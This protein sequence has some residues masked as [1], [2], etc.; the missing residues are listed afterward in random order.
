MK[1]NILR[2]VSIVFIAIL[3]F[4]FI[5]SEKWFKAGSAP[6]QY[7]MGPDD[8][9]NEVFSIKSISTDLDESSFGT[10]MTT[11]SPSKFIEK[12][13]RLTGLVKSSI[14]TGWAGLWLRIDGKNRNETLGFDNMQNRPIVNSTD[15][16]SYSIVLDIPSNAISMSYGMLLA[17]K[18]QV[19]FKDVSIDI[20]EKNVPIT[21]L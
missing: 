9:N 16:T 3:L 11:E 12:R 5:N 4:S 10:Y 21:G 15:W 18:G 20:V 2:S 7:Q 6:T 19:W 1:Q 14:E 13:V 8:K 17:G